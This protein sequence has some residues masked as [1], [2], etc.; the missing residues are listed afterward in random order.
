LARSSRRNRYAITSALAATLLTLAAPCAWS[1]PVEVTGLSAAQLLELAE[2]LERDDQPESARRIYE[3]L[4]ADPNISIRN[5]ARFR[6][7]QLLAQSD[8]SAEAAALYRAILAEQPDAQ[9]VRIELSALLA[10]MGDMSGARRELRHARAGELPPEIAR[11]VDQFAAALRSTQPFGASAELALAPSNNINRATTAATLDTVIAPFQLSEDARAQS[12]VGVRLSGQAYARK[13][14]SQQTRLTF[15]LA[16][17]GNFYRDADF[18]D[19]VS[20]V[21]M[22]IETQLPES[23]VR[24]FIGRSYRWFG[25]DAYAN[26]DTA[27]LEMVRPLGANAQLALGAGFG[28]ADYLLNDLQDG[29]I[30][31]GDILFKYAFS[32]R[33]GAGFG[34]TYERHDAEDPGYATTSG[35][36]NLLLWRRLG[37][38]SL[39]LDAGVAR[40]VADDR[41]T[42]FPERREEWRTSATFGAA[43]S[44]FEVF[45]FAPVVRLSY[46]Q[47]QSTVGIYDYSRL[48][49]DLGLTRAF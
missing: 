10:H 40:L 20:S 48:A 7:G 11:A 36:L 22:G 34:L 16:S 14:L 42:L 6:H 35:G 25:G 47:N 17:Q 9:R 21:Q 23:Q 43:L 13:T 4:E 44:Q 18:N 2:Q 30:Y 39:F 49:G 5:E 26:T 24:A 38:T 32:E 46:E 33:S 19:L 45:G 31:T 8:Q 37:E 12:G 15:R 29:A 41:L 1:E 28:Q 3:A 27:S